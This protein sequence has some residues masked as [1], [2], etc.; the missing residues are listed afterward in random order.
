MVCNVSLHIPEKGFTA[1]VG[2]SGCGKSTLA[3]ILSGENRQ[4]TGSAQIGDR[5]LQ[6][7]NQTDLKKNITM[8]GIRSYIFKGTVRENLI[9]AKPNA[10]DAQ[11]WSVLEKVNLAEFLKAE[12]GLETK[13]TEKGEN[14]SGGQ[15]Q[16]LAVARALLHDSKI[17][18]ER[19][20]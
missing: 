13:L 2:E 15:R 3:G 11:M 18:R 7:V 8:I 16:R 17:I 4:Y 12:N 20:Y 1:I 19:K 6:A 5:E 14:F 10:T 9:M